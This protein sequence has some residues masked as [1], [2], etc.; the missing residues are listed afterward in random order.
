MKNILIILL[1]F[2]TIFFACKKDQINSTTQI[3]AALADSLRLSPSSLQIE[4]DS[5]F[6]NAYVWRNFM[7]SIGKDCYGKNKSNFIVRSGN[8]LRII[9]IGCLFIN[10]S[11]YT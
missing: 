10:N 5:L 4:N 3:N 8:L 1:F 7:P 11:N 6:L 2:T 9:H